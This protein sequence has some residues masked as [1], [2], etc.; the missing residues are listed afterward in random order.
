M[1]LSGEFKKRDM[2]SVDENMKK[3]GSMTPPAYDL[4]K[5]KDFNIS[6]ICGRTDLL[7]S[8]LDYHQLKN[9]LSEN[10]NN[11]TF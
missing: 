5:I 11:I 2:G 4:S 10:G 3:Y 7:S 6:M 1:V 9:K 8:P